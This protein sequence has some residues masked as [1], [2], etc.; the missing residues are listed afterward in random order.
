VSL[1]KTRRVRARGDSHVDSFIV[2]HGS[3]WQG[4]SVDVSVP[5]IGALASIDWLKV[6]PSL[7]LAKV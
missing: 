6:G 5:A 2:V 3:L 1:E 4:V 7:Q